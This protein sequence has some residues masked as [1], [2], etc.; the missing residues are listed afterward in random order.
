MLVGHDNRL[1]ISNS[2]HSLSNRG[3]LTVPGWGDTNPFILSQKAWNGAGFQGFGGCK[4]S[5]CTGKCCGGGM[6]GLTF[7]GTGF[8][9]TGLFSSDISEWG[10]GEIIFGIVGVYA[11]Y[12]MFFQAKQT[13][14]RMEIG[15]GRR[16]K[17]RAARLRTKAKSLEEQTT[18]IF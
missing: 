12:S 5:G 9:G 17:T 14:Y 16:R 2:P 7:D 18:G 13:K 11:I 4:S 10:I 3:A 8:L 1:G 6:N 15:A